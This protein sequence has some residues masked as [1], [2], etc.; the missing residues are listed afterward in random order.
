[1][2]VIKIKYPHQFSIL[3]LKTQCIFEWWLACQNGEIEEYFFQ[4]ML[5]GMPATIHAKSWVTIKKRVI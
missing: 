4:K 3:C 2:K 1:M 5:F